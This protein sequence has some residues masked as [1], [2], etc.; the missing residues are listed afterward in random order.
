MQSIEAIRDKPIRSANRVLPA[1]A[2]CGSIAPYS[3]AQG[4]GHSLRVLGRRAC[5]GGLVAMGFPTLLQG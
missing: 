5:I 3:R 2:S 1:W 4:G